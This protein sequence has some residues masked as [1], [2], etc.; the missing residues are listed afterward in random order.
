MGSDF[1]TTFAA[2]IEID[3]HIEILLLGN[4]CVTIPGFGGFTAHYVDARYDDRDNTFLPPLRTIGF[5]PQLN[6]NDSLL[7]QSYV[8]AYDISYPDAMNRIDSEVAEIRCQLESEGQYEFNDLGVLYL[9]ENGAY[10]FEPCEAGILTPELYGLGGV[11]ILPLQQIQSD[12]EESAELEEKTANTAAETASV[13]VKHIAISPELDEILSDEGENQESKSDFIVIRK[14]LLRNMVAACIALVAF[15]ALSSPLGNTNVIKSQIDTALLTR[16][17]N[18]ETTL[19]QLV[20]VKPAATKETA[21][22]PIVPIAKPQ[23]APTVETEQKGEAYYSIV[24]ASRVTKR[25]AATYAERLQSMG[26]K[27]TKVVITPNNVKVIYGVYATESEAS[28]K[29]HALR[30][31]EPF[32]DGWITKVED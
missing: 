5:N 4:D 11:T 3:R 31:N 26:Y 18:K 8:E 12:V 25:N 20:P 17:A 29:L 2:M 23:N 15:F 1:F 14:S 10:T 16:I 28:S 9:N 30:K 24:L 21:V 6:M 27:D 32:A 7:A 22:T 19:P 13:S